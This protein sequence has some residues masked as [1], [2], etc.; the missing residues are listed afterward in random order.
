MVYGGTQRRIRFATLPA[1][2]RPPPVHVVWIPLV[3]I[4]FEELGLIEVELFI[5]LE[6]HETNG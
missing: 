6:D 5:G 2:V 1:I 3:K 4:I